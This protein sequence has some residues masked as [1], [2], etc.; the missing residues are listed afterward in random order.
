MRGRAAGPQL[1]RKS[2]AQAGGPQGRLA[3]RNPFALVRVGFSR[4]R[5]ATGFRGIA[6]PAIPR[7]TATCVRRLAR[8]PRLLQVQPQLRGCFKASR[9][10]Q[11][12]ARIGAPLT[13]GKCCDRVHRHPRRLRQRVRGQA[14]FIKFAARDLARMHRCHAIFR[15]RGPYPRDC[16][17]L[18]TLGLSGRGCDCPPNAR[19]SRRRQGPGHLR[20]AGIRPRAIQPRDAGTRSPVAAVPTGRPRSAGAFRQARIT[21]NSF[22]QN[23]ASWRSSDIRWQRCGSTGGSSRIRSLRTNPCRDG[24]SRRFLPP[25]T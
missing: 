15:F 10:T 9:P 8:F 3:L 5:H 16:P 7:P 2:D 1:D 21:P 22:R 4:A 14:D 11:C 19:R 13:F 12:D 24:A 18:P 25:W 17:P 23:R 6:C 20:F